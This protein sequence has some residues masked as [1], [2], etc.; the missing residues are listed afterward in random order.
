MLFEGGKGLTLFDGGLHDYF[1]VQGILF[2]LHHMIV[3][4][5]V[6]SSIGSHAFDRH[7]NL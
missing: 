5:L 1:P 4:S 7:F 3:Q 6:H 2:R